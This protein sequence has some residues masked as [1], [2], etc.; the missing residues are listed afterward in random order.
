MFLLSSLSSYSEMLISTRENH[1]HEGET[2]PKDKFTNIHVKYIGLRN[3]E[4]KRT[5]SAQQQRIKPATLR[6]PERKKKSN[7]QKSLGGLC[8]RFL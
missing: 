3:E 2:P 4:S 1:N 7:L 6:Y 8:V 5:F